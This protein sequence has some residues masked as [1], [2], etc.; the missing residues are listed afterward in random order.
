MMS[1]AQTREALAEGKKQTL[2]VN[3]GFVYNMVTGQ[4]ACKHVQLHQ[5]A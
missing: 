4:A 3:Q 2:S 1:G 5:L